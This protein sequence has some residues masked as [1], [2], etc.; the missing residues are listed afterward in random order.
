L[1]GKRHCAALAEI[2]RFLDDADPDD[3]AGLF[4]QLS[5]QPTYYHSGRRL[6]QAVLESVRYGF[7]DSV[8]GETAPKNPYLLMAEFSLVDDGV[9]LPLQSG[10]L[11]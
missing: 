3:E 5:F 8:R 7:F 9:S 2:G 6:V 1:L 4:G 10:Q 11:T